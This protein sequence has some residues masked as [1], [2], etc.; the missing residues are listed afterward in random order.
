MG[1]KVGGWRLIN[2]EKNGYYEKREGVSGREKEAH[3][4]MNVT[5]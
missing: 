2:E 4:S 1:G 3:A 5:P